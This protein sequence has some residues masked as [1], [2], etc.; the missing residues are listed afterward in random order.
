MKKEKNGQLVPKGEEGAR[1]FGRQM[2]SAVGEVMSEAGAMPGSFA[3]EVK[4]LEKGDLVMPVVKGV[5]DAEM[6]IA[7]P[8]GNY[9]VKEV[10]G[11]DIILE[12]IDLPE[13]MSEAEKEKLAKEVVEMMDKR[14]KEQISGVVLDALKA[15]RG[16]VLQGMKE[17]L[18]AGAPVSLRRKRGCVYV[19]IDGRERGYE[20]IY[21]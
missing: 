15:K 7:L 10:R 8:R 21:L 5:K 3:F 12:C 14:L 4:D 18:L 9:R 13:T 17:K 19:Q 20:E 16:G 1:E 2:G 6:K 11:T